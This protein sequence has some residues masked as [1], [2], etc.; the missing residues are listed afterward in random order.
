[1]QILNIPYPIGLSVIKFEGDK[2]FT[3]TGSLAKE[4]RFRFFD[5]AYDFEEYVQKHVDCKGIEFDSEYSQFFAYAK[6]EKRA[7]KFAQD[8][9][10]WF[11]NLKIL[12][13]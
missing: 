10:D 5:G 13:G 4:Y 7:K 11:E 6:S 3:I 9:T 12:V 2:N 8:V 1:M